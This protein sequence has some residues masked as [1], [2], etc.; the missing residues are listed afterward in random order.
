MEYDSGDLADARRH[1][2]S[3]RA[4]AAA[5]LREV[6][7][8]LTSPLDQISWLEIAAGFGVLSASFR[9]ETS[10]ATKSLGIR[11][12]K[13]A[14]LK[15]LQQ[16]IGHPV[17]AEKLEGVSGI[18]EWARRIR[19]LRV[20]H[21]WRIES[22]L[23]RDDIPNDHYIL[24]SSEPDQNL[25]D[26]WAI[27]KRIRN[28]KK[29]SGKPLAAKDK[30]LDYLKEIYP[31]FADKEQLSYITKKV[32]EWPRRLRELEE[33]GWDI[34]S[35]I[36][37]PDLLP[38]SYRLGSL[39]QGP[40]RSREAIK[41][42]MLILER[43]GLQCRNCGQKPGAPGVS[44]QV[45]HILPVHQGGDNSD[46]NLVT[47]CSHCHGGRHA[48]MG[49]SVRDELLFPGDEPDVPSNHPLPH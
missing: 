23:N 18:S 3:A 20:E 13:L 40:P 1:L 37:D 38:G 14:I 5:S 6:E 8:A 47:L 25:A 12:A 43:D 39:H 28:K 34:R 48:T 41:Q 42:R 4:A 11:S 29:P 16:N 31:E 35:N 7:K 2:E 32:N 10:N 17:P 33:D 21:G 36:D 27:A 26:R 15:Y 44:L 49:T 19:E 9:R 45:H 22:G 30:L 24:A 46:D